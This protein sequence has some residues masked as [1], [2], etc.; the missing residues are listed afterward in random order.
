MNQ[1]FWDISDKK[2]E[3]NFIHLAYIISF[4]QFYILKVYIY[5]KIY[6]LWIKLLHHIVHQDRTK[7]KLC[8]D[9]YMNRPPVNNAIGYAIFLHYIIT[10]NINNT[11]DNYYIITIAL[12]NII[13]NVQPVIVIVIVIVIVCQLVTC[14]M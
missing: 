10:Y 11:R 12:C 7:K 5:I 6:V 13:V 9:N 1:L 4:V 8:N 3:G 2:S 14:F